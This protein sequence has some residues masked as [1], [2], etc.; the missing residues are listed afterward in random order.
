MENDYRGARG[1]TWP[2]HGRLSESERVRVLIEEYR[3]LYSL[4]SFRVAAVDRR[5]PVAGATLGA[6]LG[7]FSAMPLATKFVL[8]LFMP[9][10]LTWLTRTTVNHARSKED[11]LRRIDEIE[12][13]VNQIAGEEL[14]LFQ[15]RHPNRGWPVSGRSGWSTV[16][17]VLSFGLA[18]LACCG[19]LFRF[20]DAMPPQVWPAYASLLILSAI[21]LLLTVARLRR[22]RYN[23]APPESC[24]LFLGRAP[25][26]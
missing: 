14:L 18:G 21:D 23:K 24:P 25:R 11:V 20:G 17:A 5:L 12:R 9:A 26:G 7:S 15:S 3:A 19:F 10:A 13:Q 4:L 16:F 8:L 2:E 1:P 6:A 22:Y